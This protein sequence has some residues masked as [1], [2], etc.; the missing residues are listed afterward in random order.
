MLA[1]LSQPS[2]PFRMREVVGLE[3]L[4]VELGVGAPQPVPA[5]GPVEVQLQRPAAQRR[6][7][8][9][10]A[11]S[12][13]RSGRCAKCALDRCTRS[14]AFAVPLTNE[15][16][17]AARNS[18]WPPL[19]RSSV[20]PANASAFSGAESASGSALL[21]IAVHGAG[22]QPGGRRLRAEL[23]QH[24][25]DAV[26]GA[27]RHVGTDCVPERVADATSR[28]LL[29]GHRRRGSRSTSST[30]AGPVSFAA[31]RIVVLVGIVDVVAGG[32]PDR[33]RADAARV[34][35]VR[36]ADVEERRAFEEERA[37]S[38]GSASRTPSGSLRPD[39]PR[40]GRSR[41]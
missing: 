37:A 17:P 6:L 15:P 22:E 34:V 20:L 36:M 14:T 5:A 16:P 18:Y 29:G 39:R 8:S 10:R 27:R 38:P 12:R 40:P 4:G 7:A 3:V 28:L 25:A 21:E 9:D 19:N 13:S 41:G 11:A 35:E 33:P 30:A 24:A 31:V 1:L 26:V 2:A 23:L 32:R